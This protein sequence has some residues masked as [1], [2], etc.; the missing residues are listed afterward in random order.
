M[1]DETTQFINQAQELSR[2]IYEAI[3]GMAQ[4]QFNVLQRLAE[5][6]RAQLSQAA[7]V[8]R[9]QLQLIATARQPQEFAAAQMDLAKEYGQKYADSMQVTMD[10]VTQAWREY[11]ERMAQV[12]ASLMGGVQQAAGTAT[13]Q[14]REAAE[15]AKKS[16]SST[17]TP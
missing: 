3:Q 12:T 10:I 17:K 11:G 9:N 14:A 13:G 7:E 6:Q 15:S 4:M 1:A 16:T 8:A 2:I 5:V